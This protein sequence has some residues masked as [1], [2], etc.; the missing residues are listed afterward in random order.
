[1]PTKPFDKIEAQ[2]GDTHRTVD[3]LAVEA[4]KVE[5][6]ARAV[7]DENPIHRNEPAAVERGYETVPAPL[8]FTRT[9]YFPRYRPDGIDE[10]LGFDLGLRFKHIVHG[11]QE[12]E[13]DRPVYVGDVLSGETTLIDVYQREGGRGGTMTFA[14]YETTYRDR[15]GD[16]VLTERMTRI[17]TGGTIDADDEDAIENTED[18][19]DS[20]KGRSST[21]VTDEA[22]RDRSIDSPQLTHDSDLPATSADLKVGDHGPKLVAD[23]E[24]ED[25]VR[26][27]GASG[28][29][30]PIHYD[31]PY[32]R[33]RGYPSVFGQGMLTASYVATVVSNWFGVGAIE[34]FGVRFR[35]QV[36]PGDTVTATGEITALED[37]GASVT[38][39]ADL[40]VSN[41]DDEAVLTGTVTATI[42]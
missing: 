33:A 25:F 30:N 32:A 38:A 42:T 6:F 10:R 13:F 11:E 21:A 2:V 3:G 34:S 8:T 27:A 41:Q 16:D 14:V 36:W 15:G 12:Y 17:E 40:A 20:H 29:F 4:G 23:L 26:Y 31:E 24:R 39:D 5:E 18:D 35:D 22:T 28:D 9:K 19:G 37:C 1:M 7:G